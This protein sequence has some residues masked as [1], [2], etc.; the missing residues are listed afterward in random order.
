M[1]NISFSYWNADNKDD[2]PSQEY[3]L[4]GNEKEDETII[5]SEIKIK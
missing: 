3:H 5:D 2:A 1:K 4:Y